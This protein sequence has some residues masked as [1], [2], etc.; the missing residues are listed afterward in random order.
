VIRLTIQVDGQE[1]GTFDADGSLV[2]TPTGSTAYALALGG[3]IVEPTLR[4]MVLVPVNPFALTVRPMVF[5]PTIALQI[6]LARF[7]AELTIDGRKVGRRML[8]GDQL[9]VAGFDQALRV[10]RFGPA[11]SFFQ[12]VR[13]KLGWGT[14]LVPQT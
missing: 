5:S 10:V 11:E 3:P 8:G 7:R 9:V 4:N 1:V 14:P 12:Q 2:A 13:Q 6:G